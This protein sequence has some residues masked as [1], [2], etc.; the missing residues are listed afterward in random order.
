MKKSTQTRTPAKNTLPEPLVYKKTI[1]K[2]D[3]INN[4][5]VASYYDFDSEE[6]DPEQKNNNV[7]NDWGYYYD[8]DSEPEDP[9]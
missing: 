2:K 3:F 1:D 9:P 8:F 6:S 5:K 4:Y 7:N